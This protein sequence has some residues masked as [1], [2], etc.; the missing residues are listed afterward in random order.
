MTIYIAFGRR[1]GQNSFFS[2]NF[3]LPLKPIGKPEAG[4]PIILTRFSRKTDYSHRKTNYSHKMPPDATGKPKKHAI[5]FPG[6]GTRGFKNGRSIQLHVPLNT[7]TRTKNQKTENYTRKKTKKMEN[8][9]FSQDLA[10]KPIIPARK[11][12]IL[13]GCHRMPPERK[14]VLST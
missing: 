1:G 4:K 11:P 14:A 5:C 2:P 13:T 12:I 8:R 6:N 10:G 9:L 7:A 3:Q